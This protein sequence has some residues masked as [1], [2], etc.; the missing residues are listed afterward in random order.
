MSLQ[1]DALVRV[2]LHDKVDDLAVNIQIEKGEGKMFEF[3]QRIPG[4][5]AIVELEA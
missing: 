4:N 3:T 1:K 2:K 5:V